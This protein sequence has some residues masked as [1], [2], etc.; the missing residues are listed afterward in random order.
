MGKLIVPSTD[1]KQEQDVVCR[2]TL[3]VTGEFLS[4]ES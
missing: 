1:V 3:K 2:C 4:K